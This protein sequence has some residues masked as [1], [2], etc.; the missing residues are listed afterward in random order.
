MRSAAIWTASASTLGD[1]DATTLPGTTASGPDGLTNRQVQATHSPLA[2]D[3]ADRDTVSP[4]A[5]PPPRTGARPAN[6]PPCHRDSTQPARAR[7]PMLR[8]AGLSEH[9][10]EPNVLRAGAQARSRACGARRVGVR[11]RMYCADACCRAHPAWLPVP[12]S[13]WLAAACRGWLLVLLRSPPGNRVDLPDGHLTPG[14]CSS[15]QPGLELPVM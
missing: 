8:W 6:A 4:R 14:A 5:R 10:P 2:V 9:G 12:V 1:R 15:G 3:A 7:S 13:R 11:R